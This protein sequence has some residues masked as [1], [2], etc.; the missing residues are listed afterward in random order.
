MRLTNWAEC[1]TRLATVFAMSD[2]PGHRR[3][4]ALW[5]FNQQQLQPSC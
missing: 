1:K 5:G 3:T 2:G 4:S